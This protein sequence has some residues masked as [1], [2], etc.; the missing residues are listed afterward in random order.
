[1]SR[2]QFSVLGSPYV[3]TYITEFI[4]D[5]ETINSELSNKNQKVA[6]IKKN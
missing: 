2:K 4:N 6:I 3:P 5:Y 1:M